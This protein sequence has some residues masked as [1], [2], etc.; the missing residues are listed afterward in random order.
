ME[1]DH[2]R[3]KRSS[4]SETLDMIQES[5][6]NLKNHPNVNFFEQERVLKRMKR[7]FRPQFNSFLDH[8]QRNRQRV[9][10]IDSQ[11]INSQIF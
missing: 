7:D 6:K 4:E 3:F 2:H 8:R 5:A 9:S 1:S 10:L 11:V